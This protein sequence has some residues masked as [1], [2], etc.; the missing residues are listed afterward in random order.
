VSW[1]EIEAFKDRVH[2]ELKQELP[3][4]SSN[5]HFEKKS[6]KILLFK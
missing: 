2:G 1:N 4:K 6:D 5:S 3:S